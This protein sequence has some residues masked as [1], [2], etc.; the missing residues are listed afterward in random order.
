MMSSLNFQ[1]VRIF[2]IFS[3][4]WLENTIYEIYLELKST[5]KI[6]SNQLKL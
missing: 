3:L 6:D 4:L 1:N 5:E 2:C